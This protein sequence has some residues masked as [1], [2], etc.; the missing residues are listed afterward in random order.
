MSK[1]IYGNRIAKDAVLSPGAS[2]IIFD[3]TRERVLTKRADNGR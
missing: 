1:L 2:A 3:E